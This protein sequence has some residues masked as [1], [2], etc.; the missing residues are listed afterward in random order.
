MSFSHGDFSGVDFS[1]CMLINLPIS[2]M[3]SSLLI[4]CEMQNCQSTGTALSNSDLSFA[5]LLN[6]NFSRSVG[7][8]RVDYSCMVT[9]TFSGCNFTAISLEDADWDDFTF[10]S[11]HDTTTSVGGVAEVKL[12]QIMQ[13]IELKHQKQLDALT[14]AYATEQYKQAVVNNNFNDFMAEIK[15]KERLRG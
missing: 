1:F 8:L 14:Q 12:A 15:E 4:G 6:C 10:Q 2:N 7:F 13:E 5:R 3:Q 11:F 9:C